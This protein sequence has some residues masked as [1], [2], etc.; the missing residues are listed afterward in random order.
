MG[1]KQ[2]LGTYHS[3]LRHEVSPAMI[4]LIG[5][6]RSKI[7]ALRQIIKRYGEQYQMAKDHYKILINDLSI[8]DSVNSRKIIIFVLGS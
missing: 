6:S 1:L 8:E 3:K 5:S 7:Y 2:W 4:D